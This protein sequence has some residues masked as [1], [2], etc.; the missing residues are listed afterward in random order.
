MPFSWFNES[1]KG[2][3]SFRN[4]P[5]PTSPLQPSPE[6]LISDKTGSK[7]ENTWI[8]KANKKNP[9]PSSCSVSGRR[10]QPVCA[11][12]PRN[13][14]VTPPQATCGVSCVRKRKPHLIITCFNTVPF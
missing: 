14:V 10:P 3:Y 2:S 8:E 4:L 5:S 6:T 11:L 13:R 9:N 12:D 1:R 7:V